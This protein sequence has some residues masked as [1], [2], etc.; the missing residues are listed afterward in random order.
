MTIS[1]TLYARAVHYDYVRAEPL[2]K[3]L[4]ASLYATR[5]HILPRAPIDNKDGFVHLSS[6]AQVRETATLHFA[7]HNHLVL[8]RLDHAQLNDLRWEPSRGGAMFPH[9]YG[10]ISLRAVLDVTE[11][12]GETAGAF[13]WPSD[14]T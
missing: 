9:V 12:A 14:I 2:F 1:R 4:T 6:R 7:G 13:S 10:D 3:I 8:I 5:E 11:L